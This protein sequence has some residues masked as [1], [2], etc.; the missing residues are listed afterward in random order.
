[1]KFIGNCHRELP[2]CLLILAMCDYI[3][4]VE[5]ETLNGTG[6]KNPKGILLTV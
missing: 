5:E 1:M 3:D 6:I 2:A 4:I